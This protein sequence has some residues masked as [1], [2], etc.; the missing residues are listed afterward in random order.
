M[1]VVLVSPKYQVVIPKVV[2]E[3][4]NLQPGQRIQVIQY[5][6]RIE[7][8]P[9]RPIKSAR[10]FLRGIDTTIEREDDRL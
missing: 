10:G 3:A 2:R 5:Q 8:V 9:L 4:L 6:N 1:S 7:L